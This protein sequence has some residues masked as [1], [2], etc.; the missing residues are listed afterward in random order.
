MR[1]RATVSNFSLFSFKLV[2]LQT[3]WFL[4]VNPSFQYPASSCEE[5]S[6]YGYPAKTQAQ[7]IREAPWLSL[8]EEQNGL[9]NGASTDC[10]SVNATRQNF[11]KKC[12]YTGQLSTKMSGF[13][14]SKSKSSFGF[15]YQIHNFA[16]FKSISDQNPR[17]QN[18]RSR[19][20]KRPKLNITANLVD[21]KTA[22]AKVIKRKEPKLQ[23]EG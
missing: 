22:S 16:I 11:E 10:S 13:D 12:S 6:G 8:S 14:I 1:P 5:L 7:W 19:M 17:S 21:R 9:N 4:N 20:A 3:S 15:N 2:I 18:P 23:T